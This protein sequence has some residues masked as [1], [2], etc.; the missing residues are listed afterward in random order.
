MCGIFGFFQSRPISLR[1]AQEMSYRLQLRGPDD[2]GFLLISRDGTV[3]PAGGSD[4]APQSWSTRTG[5]EPLRRLDEILDSDLPM[6]LLGHRRLA[7]QDL[8]P[9]GHQP[10]SYRDRYWV[11]YN[12]EIYNH[13][14]LRAELEAL[15][16]HFRSHSDTEVLLAAYVQWGVDCLNRLNGMWSFVLYDRQAQEVFISRDRFGVKPF[17]Y[18]IADGAFIFGSEPKALL[19]HPAAS[20]APNL[21]YLRRFAA[22]GPAE[23]LHETAFDT[24]VRLENASYIQCTVADLLS[25]RF[26]RKKFW[27]LTPNLSRERFDAAK[28]SELAERYRS[29]LE[30]AVRVRMRADVKIG[31]ALSGGLDSS[32]IVFLVNKVLRETGQVDR[33]ETFSCVYKAPGTEDCDEGVYIDLLA[34]T[35]QVRSNQIEP[36][37][38]EIP[39]EY[40]KM[41]Q[42]MDTPPEN[43][44]M[45]GWHTFKKVAQTSVRVTLDG[46]GADEQL[47]GYL[48]YIHTYLA[49]VSLRELWCE[50][51]AFLRVPGSA[52]HVVAGVLFNLMARTGLRLAADLLC[53]R[54]TGRPFEID[55]NA[56]LVEDAMTSMLTLIHYSDRVSMA[57]SIES[58]MP[59][60]DY[61]L[62]EFLAQVPACY[63]MHNGWT[64]YLARHAFDAHLPESV[65]WRKDK[66]G[67]PIP[68]RHWFGGGLRQWY[69]SVVERST[70][71]RKSDFIAMEKDPQNA[72]RS[73]KALNIAAWEQSFKVGV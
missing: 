72:P 61:R 48:G 60:L 12:G 36:L 23:H 24:I 55:L 26:E 10:M 68:E 29:L 34:D 25:G 46:Q 57:H 31:S 63:K 73:L 33:Q 7:I 2:E 5:F 42:A 13:I 15:G 32:S 69:R 27:K 16:H 64:K 14:E 51:R 70:L 4:T 49:G 71:L 47:A 67:W 19:V 30:D 17:Y 40:L 44:C 54:M 53:R 28:A 1:V 65:C 62:A 43:T 45:S 18:T 39:D 59:F 20:V 66:M 52:K 41:I 38:Q 21:G 56:R 37:E 11:V 9:L 58:R 8:S 22:Q 50:G 6:H 35:L 3:V